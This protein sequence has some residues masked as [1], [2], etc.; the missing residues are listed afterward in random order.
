MIL[1][2]DESLPLVDVGDDIVVELLADDMWEEMTLMAIDEL[3]GHIGQLR[4]MRASQWIGLGFLCWDPKPWKVV[5][6]IWELALSMAFVRLVRYSKAVM[7][8]KNDI[9]E[10]DLDRIIGHLDTLFSHTF[11]AAISLTPLGHS[12]AGG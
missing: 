12:R 1:R 6:C 3:Q 5:C 8:L 10:S 2:P 9:S 7:Q 11:S 4:E